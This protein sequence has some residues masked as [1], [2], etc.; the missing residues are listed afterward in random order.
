MAAEYA[1]AI[2][3]FRRWRNPPVH[4]HAEY[5]AALAQLDDMD[6]AAAAV[7][8]YDSI[9]PHDYDLSEF[10]KRHVRICEFQTD[11]DHWIEGYRKA[12]FEV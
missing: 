7:K 9:R 5:A 1:E 4:M 11:R 6:A 8:T 12:G 10:A 2:E 3:V